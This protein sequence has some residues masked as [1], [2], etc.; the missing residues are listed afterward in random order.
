M[1]ARRV[2]LIVLDGVG[3]G[4]LP[5][6]DRF[7]DGG[8]NT[9]LHALEAVGGAE[10]PTLQEL[11]LG[12]IQ[13]APSLPPHPQPRAFWGRMAEAGPAKDTMLGHWELLGLIPSRPL[14]TYPNGFPPEVINKLQ[15]IWGRRIIGNRPASGTRIIEE[16]G[17]EHLRGGALIVYTSADSVLQVAAHEEVVPPE[18]LYEYCRRARQVMSG[19][20]AV[21]RIIARPFVG[22]PGG[23]T[24][25]PRR[26]DF[27][28]APPGPT[29][30]ERLRAAGVR[31]VAVGK[32]ADILAHKAIDEEIPAA[33]NQEVL[34]R[35]VELLERKAQ[36]LFVLANLTDFDTLYGHRNN[37]RG[38]VQAL[39]AFDQALAELLAKMRQ[40]DVL[41]ISADHG[42]DPTTPSTD[43]SREWVPVLAV[44]GWMDKGRCVGDRRTFADLGA[45]VCEAMGAEPPRD[46]RSF[47]GIITHA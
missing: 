35:V 44:V 30:L 23:F 41:F 21:G 32:V 13:A 3:V 36:S 18:R 34:E 10:L 16:L 37:P 38:F 47:W 4:A 28:L 8:S 40:D 14:P 15:T 6:A 42:C 9:L 5:D 39:R 26:K 43:H 2:F 33:G 24:R 29:A 45:T 31:T 17:A 22:R 46:G 19:E 20:H 11:G 25:T 12:N 27:A 7:G 1:A